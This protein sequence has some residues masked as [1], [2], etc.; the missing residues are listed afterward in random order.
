MPKPRVFISHSAKG[1]PEIMALLDDL[2]R[3]LEEDGRFAVL[4]DKD[5]LEL[6]DR[7][8]HTLNTWIGG[9]D[10]AIVL[11]TEKALQSTYVQYEVNVLT[12]RESSLPEQKCTL[13]PIFLSPVTAAKVRELPEFSPSQ[14]TESQGFE[15]RYTTDG[16]RAQIVGQVKRKLIGFQPLTS[17]IE[18]QERWIEAL[19]T[20]NKR[21]L[22]KTLKDA[23]DKLKVDLG[24]WIAEPRRSLALALL[25][26]GL[27]T[28]TVRVI[29]DLLPYI[30]TKEDLE[31]L[32]ETVATSWI[33]LRS[34]SCLQKIALDVQQRLAALNART[35]FIARKYVERAIKPGRI[36]FAPLTGVHAEKPIEELSDEIR[37]SLIRT[38]DLDAGDDLQ[39][40]L[41]TSEELGD[42]I[43]VSMAVP[44][45]TATMLRQLRDSFPGVTFLLLAGRDESDLSA[46]VEQK[47]QFLE[48]RL[49]KDFDEELF[50]HNYQRYKDNVMRNPLQAKRE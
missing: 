33:D 17:S 21:L 5:N 43:F 11:L 32:F 27:N 3:A 41:Q 45:I 49:T 13:I 14:F 7:W 37:R 24:G 9:C 44:G 38:L 50:L 4:I 40:E 23:L 39:T 15:G 31:S 34:T 1:E 12:Y 8:R 35:D 16:D 19:L 25:S 26:C 42:P 47:I 6:G 10:I 46:V 28:T 29:L 30:T 2:R 20:S 48:P 22:D 18:A 36:W